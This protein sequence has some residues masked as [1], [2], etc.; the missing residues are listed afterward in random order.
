MRHQDWCHTC[1]PDAPGCAHA[2]AN[3]VEGDYPVVCPDCSHEV[4]TCPVCYPITYEHC[5][6]CN[7]GSGWV[8]S[9]DASAIRRTL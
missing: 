9:K 1:N 6:G 2:G 7:G 4:V 3:L 5:A 8:L